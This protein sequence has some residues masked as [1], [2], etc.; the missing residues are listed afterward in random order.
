MS[1]DAE[2]T[3]GPAPASA[4]LAAVAAALQRIDARTQELAAAHETLRPL[5][6][7]APQIPALLAIAMDSFD[8]SMRAAQR[9][10]I[11]VERGIFNGAEAALRLGTA[12]DARTVD[13]LDTLLKSGVLAADTLKVIGKFGRALSDTAAAPPVALGV[14]GLLRALRRPAVRRAFGFLMTFAE[15]FGRGLPEPGVQ[16]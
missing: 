16:R 12:M 1:L 7:L 10:G 11:D 15:Q 14:I 13:E 3:T 4:D 6:A 5:L 2:V 9:R 8:E